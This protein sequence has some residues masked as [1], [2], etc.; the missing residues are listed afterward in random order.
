MATIQA[1]PG[2]RYDPSQVSYADVVTPPYDVIEEEEQEALYARHEWNAIR[3]VLGKQF[4]HD[5]ARNNR[6]T[7]AARHLDIWREEGLFIQDRP[8]FYPYE[9][10]FLSEGE[11]KTRRGIFA[12]VLLSPWGE[13]GIYPHE[14]TLAGP[15][16]DR[17]HLMRALRGNIEPVFGLISD[18]QGQI[19][20]A[21]ATAMRFEPLATIQ[22]AS[23][24]TNRIWVM[25]RDAEIAEL[26][27]LMA[28]EPIFIADG[29][30]R[31]ETS[32]TYR[33]EVRQ[34]MRA[35][36]QIPPPLGSLACDWVMMVLVP[37]SDPGLV[38]WPTHRMVHSLP[39]FSSERFLAACQEHFTVLPVP[40]WPSLHE[41]LEEAV[42]PSFG[43]ALPE[44]LYL[45]RLRDPKI[46]E[47]R[48]PNAREAWRDLD[49]AILQ[50]LLLEDLLGIDEAKLLAKTNILYTKDADEAIRM[51]KKGEKGVQASFLLRPTL[52]SQVRAVAS[53]GAVMPQKSTYFYPK[54][55]SGLVFYFFW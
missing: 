44:G 52:M 36:G 32:L 7:R 18:P 13:G 20:K 27:T 30:H 8:S 17:L 5:D 34:A 19:Q 31:Y 43:L 42:L 11:V 51:A 24:V 25:D 14:K 55:L 4:P 29:H 39:D 22:E 48:A 33:D 16:V 21:I 23:G 2:W 3:L 49:V 28:P 50:L 45:L 37:D 38:I 15:K 47:Q 6:Y 12:T 54:L 35:A 9:Q 1:F 10:T 26:V 46:M 53:A 40:D 41:H